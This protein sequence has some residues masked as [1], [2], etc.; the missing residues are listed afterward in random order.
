[1]KLTGL[2]SVGLRLIIIIFILYRLIVLG[3]CHV[4]INLGVEGVYFRPEE[5]RMVSFP[6]RSMSRYC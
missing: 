2:P 5:E 6:S 1:M 4:K 3:L